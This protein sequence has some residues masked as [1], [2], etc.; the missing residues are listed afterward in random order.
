[1]PHHCTAPP[2]GKQLDGGG[3]VGLHGHSRK[4]RHWM[5]YLRGSFLLV[6]VFF[7]SST[8]E[9]QALAGL[10]RSSCPSYITALLAGLGFLLFFRV[11]IGV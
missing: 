7:A 4:S 11:Y 9:R 6:I 2:G 10:S 8:L 1:M 5:C 3:R